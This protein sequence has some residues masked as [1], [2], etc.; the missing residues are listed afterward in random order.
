MRFIEQKIEGVYVIDPIVHSDDRG[1]FRR[2]LC[3]K[4]LEKSKINFIAKQGNI[5]ENF[6]RYTLRGFHY[7]ETPSAESKILTCVTGAIYNIVLDLRRKSKTYKKWV[8]I[9]ISAKSKQ[10][11]FVP[12]G[13]ANAYLTMID[14]TI[15][16]YYMGDF[17][18]PDSY[19]G[20]RFNDPFF[21]FEWPVEPKVISEKDMNF[22]DFEDE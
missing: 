7:Q 17:F 3:L 19:R 2:S 15:V 4:E 12:A 8:A 9:E 14:D 21:A 10:S 11:I 5:S 1:L 18:R 13:C 22:P 16:H 20:I 6:N